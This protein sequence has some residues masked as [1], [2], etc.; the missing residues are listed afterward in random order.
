MSGPIRVLLVGFGLAGEFF[1]AP[2]LR[3]TEGLTIAGV[4][5]SAVNKAHAA[6]PGVPVFPDAAT[7]YREAGAD[8]AVIAAPTA[9]HAS[10][11]T[12]ALEAGLHAVVDKPFT[13][14]LAEAEALA[15]L[16]HTRGRLLSVFQN[17]RWDADFLEVCRLV[18]GGTLG[19]IAQFESRYDR[20]RPQV[21]NRWRER[22]GPGAGLWFDLG[23]HLLD[24]AMLLFGK[25][26]AI[27]ADLAIQRAGGETDDSFYALLRYPD[28]L[29]VVLQGGS[30]LADHGLRF[31]VHGTEGSYVKHGLDTQAQ[32]MRGG[33]GPGDAGWGVDP[34]PGTLTL[35][36]GRK[37]EALPASP[38]AYETFYAGVRDAIRNGGDGP[39]PLRKVL[40]CMA[41][42]EAAI[43]S[44]ER[45]AEVVLD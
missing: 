22:S 1:H 38:G 29:R 39:V 31:A 25:P 7:A 6:L 34:V 23:A 10:L 35:A 19:R 12:A 2:L 9:Q 11:A 43:A 37:T 40:D 36:D 5:T 44:S 32:A 42:L 28:G 45:R 26:R 14:T 17:R 4:V 3:R 27:W 15:N 41:V 33:K 13:T 8:L 20:F 24:Q 18:R 16:A 21:V 30:L